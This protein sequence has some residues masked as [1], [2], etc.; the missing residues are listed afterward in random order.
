[1]LDTFYRAT[2]KSSLNLCSAITFEQVLQF[3]YIFVVVAE[4]SCFESDT[5]VNSVAMQQFEVCLSVNLN[6]CFG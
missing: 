3:L 6:I 4:R 1:M 5:I 2:S